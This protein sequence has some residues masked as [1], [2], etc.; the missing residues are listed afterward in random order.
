MPLGS[1]IINA[2]K[3]IQLDV[4]NIEGYRTQVF[5]TIAEKILDYLS[6]ITFGGTLTGTE[7]PPPP[8][9]PI[10][11]IDTISGIKLIIPVDKSTLGNQMKILANSSPPLSWL[12]IGQPIQI[13][14]TPAQL[15]LIG[16]TTSGGAI[17]TSA[18]T[19]MVI[20]PNPFVFS[21]GGSAEGNWDIIGNQIETWIS[22][23]TANVNITAIRGTN[24]I[25]A[26]GVLYIS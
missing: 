11:Y 23:W 3:N 17:I 25:V 26:S 7:T 21:D 20:P 9:S 19:T 14:F 18:T 5:E 24:Q 15:D 12:F 8:A 16:K 22:T 4:N 2:A 10:P 13:S 1:D 6:N